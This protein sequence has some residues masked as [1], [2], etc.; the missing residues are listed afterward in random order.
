MKRI[1][2]TFCIAFSLLLVSCSVGYTPK[3]TL[4]AF[5]GSIEE[6]EYIEA[7]QQTTLGDEG[8]TELYC[9][10]MDKEHKSITEKGGVVDIEIINEKPSLEED[11][12]TTVTLLVT[13]GNGTT[14]EE[15]C[16]MVK[17]DNRWKIDV[18]LNSK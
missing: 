17:V 14:H 7:L 13:Y 8:D 18:N 16:E 6:G 15:C 12:R 10:I 5:W 3:S 4:K 9:A 1:F 2:T 11:N